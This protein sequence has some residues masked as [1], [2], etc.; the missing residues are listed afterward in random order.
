M[1]LTKEASFTTFHLGKIWHIKQKGH[2]CQVPQLSLEA[3][4]LFIIDILADHGCSSF[5]FGEN[6]WGSRQGILDCHNFSETIKL[7]REGRVSWN[8]FLKF[9]HYTISNFS[10]GQATSFQVGQKENHGQDGKGWDNKGVSPFNQALDN[11]VTSDNTYITQSSV[12]HPV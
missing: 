7:R 1:T 9:R 12:I 8:Q 10:S 2:Y 6:R 3:P 4:C 5:S 11:L